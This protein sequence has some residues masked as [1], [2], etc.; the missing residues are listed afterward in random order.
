MLKVVYWRW[1]IKGEILKQIGTCPLE[2]SPMFN[3]VHQMN[4]LCRAIIEILCNQISWSKHFKDA[5]KVTRV[6]KVSRVVKV[7]RVVK[8]KRTCRTVTLDNDEFAQLPYIITC[9]SSRKLGRQLPYTGPWYRDR[10]YRDPWYRGDTHRKRFC[11]GDKTCIALTA[12][13]II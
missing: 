8:V 12:N 6:V 3:N 4:K 5:V 7:T 9:P 10:W 1:N 11:Y 13:I 2:N